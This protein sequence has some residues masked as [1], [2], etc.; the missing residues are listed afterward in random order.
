METPLAPNSVIDLADKLGYY[1][2][3]GVDVTLVRVGATP[4][5]VAALRA[6]QGDMANVSFDI[7]LQLVA[8]DQM[9]LRGVISPDKALPFVIVSKESITAPKQL[10]GK[11][12][13]IGRI[14]SVD[15]V[16]TRNV[17]NSYGVNVDRIRYLPLGQPGVRVQALVAGQIDATAITIGTWTTMPNRAGLGMLVNQEKYYEAAPF[18]TKLS[19]VTAETAK[20]RPQDVEAVVR[21][22]ITASRDFAQHPEKW[23]EAM[24]KARPDVPKDQLELLAKAYAHSWSVNGG[25]DDHELHVTTTGLYQN[26]EFKSLPRQVKPAEWIDKSFLNAVLGKD[27]TYPAPLV[28]SN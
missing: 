3:A 9:Q 1:K 19:V 6:G 20:A 5:A 4:A 15:Y 28:T 18:I 14:G 16:Q 22:T 23:V 26:E 25:L 2:R 8:R 10:E 11:V 17:L 12:V 27:G 7:A 24:T 13:G 21:A